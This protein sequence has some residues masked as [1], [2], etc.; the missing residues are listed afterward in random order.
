[1]DI[2]ADKANFLFNYYCER[3]TRLHFGGRISEDE[4]ACEAVITAV[5]RELHLMAVELFD[6]GGAM[7]WHRVI[8]LQDATFS[9][10]LL[11]DGSFDEWVGRRWHSVVVVKYPDA[12]TLFFAER[13]P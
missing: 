9:L 7:T 4:A 1:M 8:P 13:M 6:H 3:Q 10:Y 5:D 2:S 11:G 12:T